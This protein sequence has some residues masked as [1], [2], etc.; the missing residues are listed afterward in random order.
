MAAATVLARWSEEALRR[1]QSCMDLKP[2]RRA[3]L[4][5]DG[6]FSSGHREL[7][8]DRAGASYSAPNESASQL[9]R[10]DSGG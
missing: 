2:A 1:L 10:G 4:L 9:V 6:R 3:L 7:K 8:T 5:E